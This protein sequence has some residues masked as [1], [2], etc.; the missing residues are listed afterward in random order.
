M[1]APLDSESI[2]GIVTRQIHLAAGQEA[3]AIRLVARASQ[4][5][6]EAEVV[7]EFSTLEGRGV[8]ESTIGRAIEDLMPGFR[9]SRTEVRSGSVEIILYIAA[10]VEI[11]ADFDDVWRNLARVAARASELIRL[12]PH[13]P[14]SQITPD[15]LLLVPMETTQEWPRWLHWVLAY[16][17]VSNA[18]L[19]GALIWFLIAR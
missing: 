3:F 1:S 7:E 14:L 16:L 12:V 17:M 2:G 8:L 15:V 18:V 5:G 19:I 6:F 13:A 4:P 11:V 9:I 10:V